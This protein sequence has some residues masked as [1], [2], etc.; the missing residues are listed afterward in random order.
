MKGRIIRAIV[1]AA[2]MRVNERGTELQAI[3]SVVNTQC[4]CPVAGVSK[5]LEKIFQ[6]VCCTDF[7][8]STSQ[9][10]IL[11]A[12]RRLDLKVCINSLD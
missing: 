6:Q 7:I 2:E 12:A 4:F 3:L 5:S 8:T 9:N 1:P 10:C 11:Q